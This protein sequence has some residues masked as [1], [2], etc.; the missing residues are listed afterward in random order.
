MKSRTP[1]FLEMGRKHRLCS[2]AHRVSKAAEGLSCPPLPTQPQHNDNTMEERKVLAVLLLRP[3]LRIQ[4]L[5]VQC[6]VH[7][8]QTPLPRQAG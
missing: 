2:W 5:H 6:N 3:Q 4:T 7:L 1:A 8:S